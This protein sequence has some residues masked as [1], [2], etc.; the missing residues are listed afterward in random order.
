[1]DKYV[2]SICGFIYDEALGHMASLVPPNTL[3]TAVPEQWLCPLCGASKSAFKQQTKS[4]IQDVSQPIAY[5]RTLRNTPY[6]NGELQAIFSNL[7]KGCEKQYKLE[8]AELFAQLSLYFQRDEAIVPHANLKDLAD[9]L[10]GDLNLLFD[11][12]N[13]IAKAL[14]D[15]GALRAL[16][17]SEKV[18]RILS[19]TLD[20]YFK[21]QNTLLENQQLYVCEICGFLYIGDTVPAICPVCKVPSLKIQ[22]IGKE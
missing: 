22:T 1:M 13:Q 12:S 7:S 20:R 6:T 18:S 21:E 3:W 15:R 11:Q 8:E 5:D 2:C 19:I 16:T 4:P 14:S 17:W 9:I 10:E